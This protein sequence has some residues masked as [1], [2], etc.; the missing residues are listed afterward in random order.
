VVSSGST[1]AVVVSSGSADGM[2]ST[3]STRRLVGR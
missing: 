3:G 1:D 2:V